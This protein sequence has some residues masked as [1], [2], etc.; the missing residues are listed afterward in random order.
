MRF[1]V[2]EHQEDAQAILEELQRVFKTTPLV[3][4]YQ[5]FELNF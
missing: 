2:E 5:V 1:N 3:H 4:N